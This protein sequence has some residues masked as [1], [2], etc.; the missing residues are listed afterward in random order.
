MEGY[1]YQMSEYQTNQGKIKT[2]SP[3][4][5]SEDNV[6]ISIRTIKEF[7]KQK[8]KIKDHL[9]DSFKFY[10]SFFQIYNEKV[11]DLLNFNT[12]SGSPGGRRYLN[13]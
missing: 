7:F 1:E 9:K 3:M 12:W 8:Q 13:N 11:Y 6:G 10:V 2:M 5:K 4:L